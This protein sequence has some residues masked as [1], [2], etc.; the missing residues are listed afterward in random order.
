M[1]IRPEFAHLYRGLKWKERRAEILERD[2][3]RCKHCHAKNGRLIQ[4]RIARADKRMWWRYVNRKGVETY[5]MWRNEKGQRDVPANTFT[6]EFFVG[7]QLGVA[8][9]DHDPE[10]DDDSNLA[11]LCRRCHIVHDANQH[12]TNARLTRSDRKDRERPMLRMMRG[13]TPY[14]E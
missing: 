8:H 2:R 9:L 10:N 12:K 7:V 5:G 3:N 13:E 14:A 6:R 11:A 4:R 1:P